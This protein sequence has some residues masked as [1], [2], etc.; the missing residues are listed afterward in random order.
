VLRPGDVLLLCLGD[1][2]AVWNASPRAAHAVWHTFPALDTEACLETT[3]R[4]ASDLVE[5]PGALLR[6][7][8]PRSARAR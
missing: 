4:A 7:P 8:R 6:A 3:W 1:S 2:H 5:R